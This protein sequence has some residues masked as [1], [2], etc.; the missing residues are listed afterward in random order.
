MFHM[1]V[2]FDLKPGVVIDEFRD[3]VSKFTEHLRGLDLAAGVS[4]IGKRQS[5]T[6]LDTDRERS[7]QYFVTMSFRDRQQSDSAYD[8][9]KEHIEPGHSIHKAV[10]TRAANPI[11]I[12]WSDI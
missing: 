1:L 4:P 5:D 2:C 11:F 10:N 9:L 6:P 12:C 3:S 7:H 8:Y